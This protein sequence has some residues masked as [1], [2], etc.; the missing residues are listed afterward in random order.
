MECQKYTLILWYHSQVIQHPT[1]VFKFSC[2]DGIP[3]FTKVADSPTNN[4]YILGVGHGTTTSL[5]GEPGTGLVWTSDVQGQ[6]FR[7][8]SAVPEGNTMDMINSFSIPGVTKFTRPVFGDGRIYIGTVQGYVYGFGAPV[9]QPLNCSSPYSYGTS[10]IAATAVSKKITCTADVRVTVSSISINSNDFSISDTPA[11]PKTLSKGGTFSFTASFKPGA[12]GLRSGSVV[13]AST[14]S[15]AGYSAQSTVRLSGTG[16]STGPLFSIYPSTASFTDVVVGG[17]AVTKTVLFL[18]QG[19][20]SLSISS[21]KYSQAALNSLYSNITS[22]GTQVG[23]FTFT[24]LPSSVPPNTDVAV[25]VGFHPPTSGN[26]SVYLIASSSVGDQSLTVTGSAG[27]APETLIEFQAVDGRGWIAYKP[28]VNFTFGN[29]TENVSKPLKMRVTNSGGPGAVA[30]AITVSKPPFGVAG[31]IGAASQVDLAEGTTLGPGESVTTTLFCSVPKAQWNTDPY[32]GFAEWTINTN[33]PKMGK[34]FVGFA[35][36]AV[37]EQARPLQP[38]G[39]G[40]YRYSGCYKENNPGRQLKALLY[41]DNNNTNGICITACA[42]AGYTYCGTQYN[43][44]C[45]AGPSIPSLKVDSENCNYPCSGDA[46]QYCG[47][48]GVSGPLAGGAYISLFAKNSSLLGNATGG[49]NAPLPPAG[50]PFTNPGVGGYTSI[51][52]YTES[53]SGRALPNRLR[54]DSATIAGCIAAAAAKNYFY[55]GLEYGKEV[56]IC[57][58]SPP[59]KPCVH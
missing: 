39:L 47:G 21:I 1:H 5:N 12:V 48:N 10:D 42:S 50:A 3:S 24:G 55:V 32:D 38:N 27:P 33:D 44:E 29:V 9:N 58:S 16:A 54:P 7:I 51:G 31:I 17:G 22:A 57:N 20:T 56:Y 35:C 18:N 19:N 15:V 23:P 52:C 13:I 49:D 2:R 53:T 34:Q 25:T 11:L 4:S 40:I 45:W 36:K 26:Y 46:N 41:G 30:M 8:Y 59:P 43:R 6:N 28:G 14:E 37:S